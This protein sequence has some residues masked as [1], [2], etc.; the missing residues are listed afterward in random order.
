MVADKLNSVYHAEYRGY[1]Y[2][3]SAASAVYLKYG[4]TAGLRAGFLVLLFDFDCRTS[5]AG[6]IDDKYAENNELSFGTFAPVSPTLMV[7]ENFF[8]YPAGRCVWVSISTMSRS[9]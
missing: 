1:E 6:E 2:Y 4:F 8:K 9:C 3:D 7:D 5:L